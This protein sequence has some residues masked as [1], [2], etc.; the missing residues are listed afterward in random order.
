[1]DSWITRPHI[2]FPCLSSLSCNGQPGA[3]LSIGNVALQ[4]WL[5]GLAF[6]AAAVIVAL[7]PSAL[8]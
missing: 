5:C 8:D 6:M 7:V 1:L 3:V 4:W 2:V